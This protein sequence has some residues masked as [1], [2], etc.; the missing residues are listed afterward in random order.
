[1][2][3]YVALVIIMALS[4]MIGFGFAAGCLFH[5]LMAGFSMGM[6]SLYRVGPRLPAAI[7]KRMME[8]LS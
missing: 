7:Q 4:P 5:A 1:M 3:Q 8:W 2:N 6:N